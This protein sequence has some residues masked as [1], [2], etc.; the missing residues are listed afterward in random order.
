MRSSS[1]D[2]AIEEAVKKRVGRP[3]PV[4][5]ISLLTLLPLLSYDPFTNPSNHTNP[6]NP[7]L[8][9]AFLIRSSSEDTAK[10]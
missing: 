3:L 6:T 1:E 2:S 5:T 10:R 8:T 7:S 9:Q 4:T